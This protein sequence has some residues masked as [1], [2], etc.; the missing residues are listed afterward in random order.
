MTDKTEYGVTV[1][2]T[3]CTQYGA[4]RQKEIIKPRLPI[5]GKEQKRKGE[6]GEITFSQ[7]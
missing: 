2:K 6:R 1:V 4:P 7:L 3:L 5:T